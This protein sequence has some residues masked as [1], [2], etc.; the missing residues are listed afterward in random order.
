MKLQAVVTQY[1]YKFPQINSI[2]LP[3]LEMIGVQR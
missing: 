1:I 3:Y 2:V